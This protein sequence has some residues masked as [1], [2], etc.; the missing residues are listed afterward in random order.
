M[1]KNKGKCLKIMRRKGT[2]P[3]CPQ[4]KHTERSSE[5]KVEIRN[6]GRNSAKWLW[7]S[8]FF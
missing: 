3:A 1:F 6:E 8:E 4:D 2:A 7:S 5:M